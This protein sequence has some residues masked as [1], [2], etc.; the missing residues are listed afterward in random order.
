MRM[1]GECVA[2]QV[3]FGQLRGTRP[4][5][6]PPVTLRGLMRKDMLLL[7]GSGGQ[8]HGQRWYQQCMKKAAWRTSNDWVL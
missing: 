8:V 4:V 5:G 1:P 2:Q 6:S 3:M 7:N